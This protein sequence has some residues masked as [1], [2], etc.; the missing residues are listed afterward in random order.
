VNDIF[1]I[2]NFSA[3]A[4]KDKWDNFPLRKIF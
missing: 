1:Q 3:V 2:L 4:L